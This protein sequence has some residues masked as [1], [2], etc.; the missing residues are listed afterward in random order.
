MGQ[1]KPWPHEQERLL[2]LGLALGPGVQQVITIV[3][4]STFRCWVRKA[5]DQ[6]TAIKIGRPR[7][8][9]NIRALV[10]RIARETGWGYSRILGKLGKLR[11]WRISRQTVKIILKENGLDN[12][13]L[14]LPRGKPDDEGDAIPLDP[15]KIKCEHRLGGILKHYYRDAA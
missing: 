4:Y 10:V 1:P 11:V 8:T 7:I 6:E 9:I 14:P 13:L 5:A 15:S 3:A 12:R 2:K